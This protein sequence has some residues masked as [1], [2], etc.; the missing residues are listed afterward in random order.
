MISM[1]EKKEERERR[2]ERETKREREMVME[3]ER[4]KVSFFKA[5]AGPGVFCT[6]ERNK[7]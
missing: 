3:R 4:E 7:K 6:I 2:K 1:R 5:V